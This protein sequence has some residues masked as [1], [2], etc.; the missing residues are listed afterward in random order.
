DVILGDDPS[1]RRRAYVDDLLVPDKKPAYSELL[2]DARGCVWAAEHVGELTGWLAMDPRKWEVFSADGEWL[3]SV[4][5]PRRFTVFEI[6][7][8]YVLGV[9]RDDV[10]VEHVQLLRLHRP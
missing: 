6:G 10:D 3:G 4:L 7:D 9:F 1:P 2:V 8:D 5:S